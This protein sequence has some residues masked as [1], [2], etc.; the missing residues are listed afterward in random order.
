MS[1]ELDP[2][3]IAAA[4]AGDGQARDQLV[5]ASMPLVYNIVGR[6][7]HGH[8]DVDDVAQETMLRALGSLG[9]LRDPGSFR[10]WLVAITM[11]QIRAHWRQGQAAPVNGGLDDAYDVPDPRADFVG[12]TI[13]R[14]GLSGQRREVAEATRWL[15]DADHALLSLWWLE[16]AGELTR[17]EVATAMELTPQ[18]TAVRVQRMKTQL[19][20]SRVV[21]RALSAKPRCVLLDTV[22]EQWDGAPSALWRKRIARHARECTV[23]SSFSSGLVPADR[24][25]VGL[26]LVPLAAALAPDTMENPALAAA[27]DRQPAMP[28][29]PGGTASPPAGGPAAGGGR[30]QLR[31]A[32]RESRRVRRRRAVTAAAV[33]AAAL[34]TVGGALPLITAG[35]DEEPGTSRAATEPE[36]AP[37][38]TPPATTLAPSPSASKA[39]R[40]PSPT[41]TSASP[42]KEPHIPRKKRIPTE[43]ATPAPRSSPAAPDPA[44]AAGSGGG[45]SAF[46]QQVTALVNSE[47]AKQGCSP[48]RG[49]DQLV[50]AARRHSQDMDARNY[51]DH[52]S[53]DGTDPGDRIKAAGYQ[54]STYGENIARGQR[55]AA[56][57]MKSWM[58]SPGHRANILNCDFKEIGI[59]THDTSG[60]PTWTQVFGARL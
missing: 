37:L 48:V 40:S 7:L 33:A 57:V 14:L 5:T 3:V 58:N 50:T 51:F 6:A 21:V 35:P 59:G 55:S 34:A 10:S 42:S 23:C 60:G 18:H 44:P 45:G 24:L 47:R 8:A 29:A 22:T 19:E 20:A 28:A 41:P 27:A 43:P 13:V 46:A 56:E 1:S 53:P 49:N 25:L 36:S 26:A 4:Q 39:S 38:A 54:W 30:A 11:N 2:A 17:A 16:A 9:D 15:D 12:L 31:D 32:L 52:T